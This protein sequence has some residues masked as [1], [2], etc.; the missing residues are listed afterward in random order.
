MNMKQKIIVFQSL[1]SVLCVSYVV[2]RFAP[3]DDIY[4]FIANTLIV[5]SVLWFCLLFYQL[6][7]TAPMVETK[8]TLTGDAYIACGVMMTAYLYGW[9]WLHVVILVIPAVDV[10]RFCCFEKPLKRPNKVFRGIDK[11][12]LVQTT[13]VV[14]ISFIVFYYG[15]NKANY[16]SFLFFIF[17]LG[18]A[19]L[20]VNL[21]HLPR[22]CAYYPQETRL[23][24]LLVSAPI[25]LC[26]LN[27]GR[28]VHLASLL[29][30]LLVALLVVLMLWVDH[31][32]C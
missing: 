6:T 25:S 17:A 9:S 31:K 16:Q 4:F 19:I 24:Y 27:I 10:V 29:I 22:L 21:M 2:T 5:A 12:L 28:D 8:L 1:M 3:Q 7:V 13:L 32:R 30:K 20:G 15:L 11:Y 26:L 14:T 18:F 23:P